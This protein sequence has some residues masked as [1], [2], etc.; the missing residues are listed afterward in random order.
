VIG[1]DDPLMKPIPPRHSKLGEVDAA[2]KAEVDAREAAGEEE[3]AAAA[4]LVGANASTADGRPAVLKE[5][6]PQREL[7]KFE[8]ALEPKAPPPDE[9][10]IYSKPVEQ[11][12]KLEEWK[13]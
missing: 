12:E 1:P 10:D 8:N 7:P 4:A 2:A 6:A 3:K 5:D 9:S 13:M 11:K